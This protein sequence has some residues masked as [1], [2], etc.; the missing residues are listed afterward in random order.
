M[1]EKEELLYIEDKLG[2]YICTREYMLKNHISSLGDICCYGTKKEIEEYLN[3]T[4]TDNMI[5]R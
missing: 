4:I 2:G 3:I 5:K 1:N